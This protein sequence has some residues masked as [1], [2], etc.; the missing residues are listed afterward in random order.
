MNSEHYRDEST[1]MLRNW[2]RNQ[3]SIGPF[4]AKPKAEVKLFSKKHMLMGFLDL[5]QRESLR[6][7]C[8]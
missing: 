5:V 3:E 1:T 7:Y 8:S 6:E 4:Q 2:L